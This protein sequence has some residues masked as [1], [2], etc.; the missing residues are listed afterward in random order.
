MSFTTDF[1]PVSLKGTN[2]FKPLKVGNN[3]VLHR[4]AFPPLTRMRA[5]SP[6]NIPNREWSVEY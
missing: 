2:L 1:E 6:G 3:T 5:E 4:A